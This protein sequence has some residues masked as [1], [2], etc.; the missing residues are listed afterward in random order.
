MTTRLLTN[1]SPSRS[2]CLTTRT[3]SSSRRC[4]QP[5]ISRRTASPSTIRSKSR[6]TRPTSIGRVAHT[7][8]RRRTPVARFSNVVVVVMGERNLVE[9]LGHARTRCLVTRDR[10]LRF[11]LIG[12]LLSSDPGVASLSTNAIVHRNF[13]MFRVI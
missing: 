4:R 13:F 12:R 1:S 6:S 8:R 2:S 7:Y 3:T 5:L 11:I 10:N 9:K